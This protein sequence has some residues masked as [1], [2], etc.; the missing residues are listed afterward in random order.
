MH[1]LSETNLR[2]DAQRCLETVLCP[3]VVATRVEQDT[4]ANL[5]VRVDLVAVVL[6]AGDLQER[7]GDLLL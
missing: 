6:L 3:I 4:Q 5:H 2:P 1:P 7:L